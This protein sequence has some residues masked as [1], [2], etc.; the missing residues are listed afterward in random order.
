M[1]KYYRISECLTWDTVAS[2]EP[3]MAGSAGTVTVCVADSAATT[4]AQH[5]HSNH[6]IM[7]RG[8]TRNCTQPVLCFPDLGQRPAASSSTPAG[9]A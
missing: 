7:C 1:V 4:P 9:L 3:G 6:H 5:M 2:A 8:L